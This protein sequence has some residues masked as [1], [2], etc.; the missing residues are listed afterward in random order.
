M[1]R[2]TIHNGKDIKKTY[3]DGGRTLFC[4]MRE[5]MNSERSLSHQ[6][7]PMKTLNTMVEDEEEKEESGMKGMVTKVER[8]NEDGKTQK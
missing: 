8:E 3:S 1:A 7:S 4:T 6:N 5:T 2:K